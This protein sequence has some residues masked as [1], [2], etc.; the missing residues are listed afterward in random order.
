MPTKKFGLSADYLC[1]NNNF[2]STG[3]FSSK[4]CLL[5]HHVNVLTRT[6]DLTHYH[7]AQELKHYLSEMYPGYGMTFGRCSGMCNQNFTLTDRT[8]SLDG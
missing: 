8:P 3:L 1:S 4:I 2:N 6:L 5:A 7:D